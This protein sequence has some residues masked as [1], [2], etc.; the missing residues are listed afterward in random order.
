MKFKIYTLLVFLLIGTTS[1]EAQTWEWT[2]HAGS[3]EQ[4]GAPLVCFDNQGS[5]FT[6]GNYYGDF[7]LGGQDL[8]F[9][10]WSAHFIAKSD[11]NGQLIWVKSYNNHKSRCTAIDSDENGNL[12]V[13]G[14]WTG[15]SIN[16]DGTMMSRDDTHGNTF[17]AKYDVNGNLLWARNDFKNVEIAKITLDKEGN[18][19][20]A[21]SYY[22]PEGVYFGG[23]TYDIHFTMN[24]GRPDG[25][26]GKFDANGEAL[27]LHTFNGS[28]TDNVSAIGT[29]AAN[30][31]Y[32]VGRFNSDSLVLD[33]S[34]T[35]FD[36]KDMAS[37]GHD[38]FIA[39]YSP[40]GVQRWVKTEGGSATVAE[41]PPVMTVDDLGNVTVISDFRLNNLLIDNTKNIEGKDWCT[42]TLI[43]Q[44][45][46]D[47]AL[48]FATSAFGSNR[49]IGTDI[50]SYGGKIY[51]TGSFGAEFSSGGNTLTTNGRFDAYV[52]E[53]DNRGNWN[54]A[55]SF[56]GEA[57][58]IPEKLT[59]DNAG[60]LYLTAVTS[61]ANLNVN[62]TTYTGNGQYDF[63]FGKLDLGIASGFNSLTDQQIPI[64]AFP[65]PAND[66]VLIDLGGKEISGFLDVVNVSG[67]LLERL[68]FTNEVDLELDFSTYPK[69]VYFVK[70]NS[71]EG[72]GIVKIIK[73]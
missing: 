55:I 14:A 1:I 24:A 17:I 58:E 15:T 46:E 70:I 37:E 29:D 22:R 52:A 60:N 27:W 45:N 31:V 10:E 64:S 40:E 50:V 72:I 12:Y 19:V 51:L 25:L 18:I 39:K 49:I 67:K 23:N 73:N 63:F 33:N 8:T 35:F 61:S 21:G 7:S 44:F 16:L 3:T 71:I 41:S 69:G 13:A 59:F 5:I 56:G 66:K 28:E 4:E 20:F 62:N 26:A 34:D 53:I 32:I 42:T 68:D 48:N 43:A 2:S 36:K 54:W 65:N 9:N 30:N 57:T 6:S 11:L 38:L 47:G